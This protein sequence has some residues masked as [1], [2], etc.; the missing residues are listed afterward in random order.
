MNNRLWACGLLAMCRFEAIL[1][2][3]LKS[4]KYNMEN[5]IKAYNNILSHCYD[6]MD[7]KSAKKYAGYSSH[8]KVDCTSK[9]VLKSF[10]IDE[11]KYKKKNKKDMIG[12]HQLT[13]TLAYAIMAKERNEGKD[14]DATV[15]EV[16]DAKYKYSL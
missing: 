15:L 13:L 14:K 7:A 3:N 12:E 5:D 10:D 16:K 8:T 9:A 1:V 4:N 11:T 6:K 2:K